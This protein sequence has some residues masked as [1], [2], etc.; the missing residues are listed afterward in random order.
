MQE[1][2][3]L[4]NAGKQAYTGPYTVTVKKVEPIAGSN[5]IRVTIFV[6]GEDEPAH[7]FTETGNQVV[8]ALFS[9]GMHTLFSGAGSATVEKIEALEGGDDDSGD[10]S[11]EDAL[12]GLLKGDDDAPE[13]HAPPSNA[14]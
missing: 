9:T 12:S 1:V 7:D 11:D 5:Q 10:D 2:T 6:T 4:L 3:S 8:A 14:S 13:Q